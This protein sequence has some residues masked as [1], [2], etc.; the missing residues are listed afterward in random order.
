MPA[1]V[2]V[3]EA[4]AQIGMCPQVIRAE[5]RAG[6]LAGHKQGT[7]LFVAQKSIDQWIAERTD[8]TPTDRRPGP[9]VLPTLPRSK[10]GSRGIRAG[11]E[12]VALFKDTDTKKARQV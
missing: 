12:I 5:I 4:S 3:R 7:K 1:F 11:H 8:E 10:G 2:S 6:R 9:A